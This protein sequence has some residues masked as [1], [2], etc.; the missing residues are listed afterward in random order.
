MFFFFLPSEAQFAAIA[1]HAVTL[2]RQGMSSSWQQNTEFL[3][4]FYGGLGEKKLN[5]NKSCETVGLND[6]ELWI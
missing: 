1:T 5:K 3:S 6:D 2:Q 4:P